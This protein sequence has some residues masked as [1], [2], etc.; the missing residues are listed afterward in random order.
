MMQEA[1]VDP[2]QL[3]SVW[4]HDVHALHDPR[5]RRRP[6]ARGDVRSWLFALGEQRSWRMHA[7]LARGR[8]GEGKATPDALAAFVE[9]VAGELMPPGLLQG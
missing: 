2:A 9:R 5:R 7:G 4:V 6:A 1:G 3:P 8:G